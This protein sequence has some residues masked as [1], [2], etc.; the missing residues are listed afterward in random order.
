[1]SFPDRSFPSAGEVRRRE[2]SSPGPL[3]RA[4]LSRALISAA[5]LAFAFAFASAGALAQ[6][7]PVEALGSTFAGGV[8]PYG[9]RS[10]GP[11]Y[12]IGPT[13]ESPVVPVEPRPLSLV[14]WQGFEHDSNV[15]ALPEQ[16]P[17]GASAI[18]GSDRISTT[19]LRLAY[20][21]LIRAQA[22]NLWAELRSIDYRRFDDL[23]HNA[24][25]LGGRWDW[26]AGREWYG[27][28]H[29]ESRRFLSPFENLNAPVKNRLELN[30]IA[31][32]AGYRFDPRWS[33]FAGVEHLSRDNSHPLFLQEDL[34]QNA[35]ESG[36]RHE[37]PDVAD[38]S[39]VGRIV[40]GDFPNG[41]R[42]DATGADL[43]SP[44]VNDFSDRSLLW[45]LDASPT[46]ASRIV[47]ELG[48]TKRRSRDAGARD[49]SGITGELVWQ[50]RTTD[51][52]GSE[53]YLRRNLGAPELL[54]PG[55]VDTLQVGTLINWRASGKLTL[56]LRGAWSDIN[57]AGD[58]GLGIGAVDER[59]D[60]L[61]EYGL[62]ISWE[63]LR[64]VLL[65]LD[66][67]RM[68][69]RSNFAA[70]RFESEVIGLLLRVR[71]D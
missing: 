21:N 71:F 66:Y 53:L 7:G 49:F 5:F 1:M 22:I 15:Y 20:D 52:L 30:R 42:R 63:I 35:F 56:S 18:S 19:G 62:A 60:R 57:Y 68:E 25:A 36:V 45:R 23:D 34:R 28:L 6:Q 12:R 59:Q 54:G 65:S 64:N 26:Q 69:R 31:A 48:W 13:P 47:G 46:A 9:T 32:S 27:T 11:F 50:W 70:F 43:P 14:V 40:D 33:G 29:A 39:L 8:D 4:R 58:S 3:L 16:V 44:I 55:Y 17:A 51:A 38:L 24:T 10:V 61:S 67:R 2:A 41:Q 37:W